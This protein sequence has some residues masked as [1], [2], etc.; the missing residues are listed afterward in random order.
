M[1]PRNLFGDRSNRYE[2]GNQPG[3]NETRD[4]PIGM[5]ATDAMVKGREMD[6]R[7]TRGNG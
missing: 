2:E 5:G 4:S 6:V 1:F 3:Q 7:E